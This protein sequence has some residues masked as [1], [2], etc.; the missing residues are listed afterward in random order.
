MIG[1]TADTN[2]YVSALQF[3]GTPLRLLN[4]VRLGTFHLAISPA[5]LS[6]LR[7]VLRDKFAWQPNAIDEAFEG[8][9]R[10]TTLV[11]PTCHIN[12]VPDD[13]DNNRVLECAVEAGSDYIVTGDGDL[14]RLGSYNGIPI[15]RAADFLTIL[16][17]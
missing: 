17:P 2:V 6:E 14:L 9:A 5:L 11:H 8:I 4:N 13:P 1:V 7:R 10:F 16:S 12:A 15:I 3:G